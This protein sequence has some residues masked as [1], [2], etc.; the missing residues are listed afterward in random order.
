MLLISKNLWMMADLN[1]VPVKEIAI[2][3][4]KCQPYF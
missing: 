3:M 1:N 2:R 4:I